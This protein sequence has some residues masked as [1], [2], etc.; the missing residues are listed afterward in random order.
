MNTQLTMSGISKSF[1]GNLALDSVDFSCRGGEIHALVGE[2]G[3]G[4]STLIKILCGVHRSDLGSIEIDGENHTFSHPKI[5]IEAGIGVVFQE[6]S[7]LPHKDVAENVFLGREISKYGVLDRRRMRRECQKILSSLGVGDVINSHQL[8]SGL[9]VAQQQMVE[10]AKAISVNSRILVLDE[11]TAALNDA[12]AKILFDTLRNLRKSGVAI[13]YISH[14]MREVFDLSDRITVLKDGVLVNVFKT[15][16]TNTGEI[17]KA[18][19]GREIKEFYPPLASKEDQ[20][21]RL[22]LLS[23][24]SNKAIAPTTLEI[25]SGQIMGVAGLEGAGQIEFAEALFGAIPF[26]SGQIEMDGKPVKLGTPRQA[27]KAN[28]GYISADRKFDGLVLMQSVRDNALLAAQAASPLLSSPSRTTKVDVAQIDQYLNDI[29]I[30]AANLEQ[31]IQYLSGGNQQKAIITRWLAMKPKLLIFVEPTR[32]IDVNTKATIYFLMRDLAK[33]GVSII[34]VSSDL[35]ELIGI[36][37]R[38]VVFHQGKIAEELN[39]GSSEEEIMFYATG[40]GAE[41]PQAGVGVH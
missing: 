20:I 27:I 2:N 34:V 23:K 4:K 19:V 13:I 6:F 24:C 17:I 3:A 1:A 5:A 37:D 8:V 21:S 7:L 39:A 15:D 10:I 38:L 32:G 12:E 28:I 22:M 26:A 29:D 16:E 18:M 31:E 25:F 14:R 30:R 40:H 36:S 35:P 9:S 41:L 33:N 11:P